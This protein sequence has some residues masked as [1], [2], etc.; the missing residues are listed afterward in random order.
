MFTIATFT[1]LLSLSKAAFAQE[2]GPAPSSV[3]ALV[4]QLRGAPT[5]ADRFTLLTNDQLLFDFNN[6]ASTVGVTTGIDGHTVQATS[7]NFPAV[8]GNGISMTIGYLGPCAMNTPHTHPRASEINFSL[9]TTLRTG[10]LVENGARFAEI[11]IRPGTATVF[12][13]GAIHFEMNP[14]CE[15][16]MF[17]AGFNGEDPGVQQVAQR[18]FGLPPDIV[19]AALGGLGVQ[20]VADLEGL[21]PDNVI[22]GVDSCL[23]KCNITRTGQPT[24]QRQPR[25]SANAFPSGVSALNTFALQ[26]GKPAAPSGVPP[27]PAVSAAASKVAAAS[28]SATAS[29]S[30]SAAPGRREEVVVRE[31][32]PEVVQFA[33]RR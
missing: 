8:V 25:V 12:P 31:P 19:G 13:M 5:E 6:P 33:L 17:V 22:F 14:S 11:D 15:P 32:F 3:A 7:A 26:T 24:A 1:V 30:A 28:A 20:E 16:A 4:A 10:V 2:G 9:N 18:F 21:I 23:A 27:N 29:A